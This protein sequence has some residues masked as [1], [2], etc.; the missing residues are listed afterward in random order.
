MKRLAIAVSMLAIG[1]AGCGSSTPSSPSTTTIFT[2]Q[3]S[4]L[5]EVP[6]I[7]NAEATARGTAV[8]TIDSVKNTVDFN[9]SL[10]SFPAGSAVNIAHIH[11]P[12]PVGNNASVVISTTLT[13]GNVTLTNGSGTFSFLQVTAPAATIAAILANPSN[14]YFNVHTTLNGGGAI[15][16]WLQ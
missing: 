12:A 1:A 13:P 9:V 5:N 4:A 15:R 3:L 16:G 14:F 11:G 8:I 10:N 2:V 6:P 7:T